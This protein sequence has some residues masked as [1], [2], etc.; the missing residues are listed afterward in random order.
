MHIFFLLF[1]CNNNKHKNGETPSYDFLPLNNDHHS[2][3]NYESSL[4]KPNSNIDKGIE[5]YKNRIFYA[6]YW[7]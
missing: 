1:S 4:Q 6:L 7:Q 2:I 5:K 3:K